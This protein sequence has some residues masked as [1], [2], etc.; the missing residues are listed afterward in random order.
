MRL[1]SCGFPRRHNKRAL[2]REQTS[3][4]GQDCGSVN[5]SPTPVSEMHIDGVQWSLINLSVGSAG[6]SPA[7]SSR[8]VSVKINACLPSP[9][10]HN[11]LG[12]LVFAPEEQD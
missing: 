12:S 8:P 9:L 5:E 7:Q 1:H 3:V 10:G 2:I 6:V 4:P 11:I